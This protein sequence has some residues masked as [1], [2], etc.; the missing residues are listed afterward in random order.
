[1]TQPNNNRHVLADGQ[2]LVADLADVTL[3]GPSGVVWALA[4]PQLNANLV[5]IDGGD[6]I[7]AHVNDEVDVLLVTE[8]GR[9]AVVIDGVETQVG[10][11]SVVLIPRGARRTVRSEVGLAYYSIHH[12]RAGVDVQR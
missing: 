12:R 8:S 2:A 10:P 4:S 3:A 7:A 11:A 6:E 1:M 9:G 5:K